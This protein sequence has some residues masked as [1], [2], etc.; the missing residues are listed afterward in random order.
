MSR[1]RR[2]SKTLI[3]PETGER[4]SRKEYRQRRK[5]ER[6]MTKEER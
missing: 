2:K 1:K 5:E 4:I 3:N 6:R